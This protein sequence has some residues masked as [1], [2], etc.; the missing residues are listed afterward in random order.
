[1]AKKENIEKRLDTISNFYKNLD[2]V[3]NDLPEAIPTNIKEL[4]KKQIL[5]DDEL[6][7]LIE[8]I[9]K[10]RAPKFIIMGRTGVGKSS[11]INAMCGKYL[12]EISNVKIGTKQAEKYEYK[13]EGS[14]VLEVLDTRGIGES[15][16]TTFTAED[17]LIRE[18][19][20]FSPDAILF[21]L[22]CKSRDRIDDD[23]EVL[24]QIID[25]WKKKNKL[26]NQNSIEIPVFVILNQADEMEPSRYKE[27]NNYVDRKIKNIELARK[28][29]A[30]ILREHS[31]IVSEIIAVSSL[32]D[33]GVDEDEIKFMS[34]EEKG[35][36]EI[37]FDGRYN[38]D[39]LLDSL[40]SNLEIEASIGLTLATRLQQLTETLAEKFVNIFSGIAGTIAITPI[41][42][43]DIFILTALQAV[44]IMFIAGLSGRDISLE[45]AKE[46]IVGF[47]GVSAGGIFLRNFAQQASKL[48]NLVYPGAGSA[49]SAVIAGTGTKL[50][51]D[52]A[53]KYF[54]KD[55]SIEEIH[56]YVKQNKVS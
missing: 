10:R 41:P 54:I 46:L 44:L 53:I 2:K 16:E 50:I 20:E 28:E 47:G 22:R 34:D 49:I 26:E 3:I 6:K 42:L 27:P 40:E 15:Q 56:E 12:A 35:K 45:T 39:K 4:I 51:G 52:V 33:W 29:V 23:V 24:K 30:Q 21:M 31:V 32:I 11:L 36:L 5:G 17:E 55:V 25:K 14:V 48:I 38:I 13:S 37:E 9:D 8:G 1:M 7:S 43:S 19:D 18:F